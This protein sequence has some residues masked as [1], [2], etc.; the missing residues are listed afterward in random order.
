MTP[1]PRHRRVTG[2]LRM[3]G[4]IVLAIA[5][6]FMPAAAGNVSAVGAT[7]GTPTAASTF[8]TSVVFTQPVALATAPDR[9]EIL[10]GAPGSIGPNVTEVPSPAGGARTLRF[11]LPLTGGHLFPNTTLTARWRLTFGTRVEIGP[12]VAVVYA[13]TRFAWRTLTG[14]LIRIHWYDGDGA[15][16]ARALAIEESG[17]RTAEQLLGVTETAPI[18]FFVYAAQAPFYDA[19]GPGTRENVGGEA[20][21]GIR[22]LFAL[23]TPAEVNASWVSTVLPHELTHLV[24]DT[25]VSN[26]YHFP[27]RWLNEGLAVYLSQGYDATDRALVASA[28]SGRTLI[29]LAGLAGQFPTTLDQFSL[30]YAESVSAVDYLVRTHGRTTLVALIRSYATGVTDDEAFTAAIGVDATAFDRAWLASIGATVPARVG[31]QPAPAGPIPPGWSGSGAAAAPASGTAGVGPSAAAPAPSIAT[32]R[33]V[34]IDMRFLLALAAMVAGVAL[35]LGLWVRERR[36]R[37]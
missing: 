6:G 33:S 24:F 35:L 30:A 7:Y 32:G 21:T 10:I 37:R 8:G 31:P 12:A 28:A 1:L 15:F 9:T 17:V 22:T 16:G 2:A 18:D 11:S 23:I 20:V 5:T 34:A 19:L 4:A 25:A 27:P 14:S 26:P 13:D 36:P 29:P 3:V